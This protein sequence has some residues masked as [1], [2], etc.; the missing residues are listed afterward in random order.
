MLLLA[1]CLE[2]TSRV[3]SGTS[4]ACISL[5]LKKLFVTSHDV[6][7][8]TRRKKEIESKKETPVDKIAYRDIAE[9]TI[10]GCFKH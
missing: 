5:G 7:D 3:Y 4:F 10:I 8:F 9:E 1:S 6:R 2:S